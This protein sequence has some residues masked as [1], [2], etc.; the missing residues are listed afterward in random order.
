MKK[1]RKSKLYHK[2]AI[3]VA[4][5]LT[6]VALPGSTLNARVGV[7]NMTSPT[8]LSQMT[9]NDKDVTTGAGISTKIIDNSIS[10]YAM[11]LLELS[12]LPY[13]D[14]SKQSR[15]LDYKIMN[16]ELTW[17]NIITLV[18]IGIDKPPYT[19]AVVISEIHA[20]DVDVLVNKYHQLPNKFTPKSLKKLPNKYVRKGA[21]NAYL[22]Y[23]A[24]S[25][26]IKLCNDA[27]NAGYNL[28][29]ST[30]YRDFRLQESFYNSYVKH[31]GGGDKGRKE[32]D[33]YSARPGFS[34]HQ[35]GL[36]VDVIMG[37][38]NAHIEK[39]PVYKWYIERIHKYGFI[40]R[41][42][43]GKQKITG[44]EFWE[45]WH[46]RYLG[47]ELA[48]KVYNSGLSYDEYYVRYI[49]PNITKEPII[50]DESISK[51]KDNGIKK[52]LKH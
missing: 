42:P 15:Y 32:A 37:D 48:I 24:F 41:Y 40:L 34:E 21:R 39:Q 1:N 14:F 38:R 25:A 16:S 3:A 30:A 52:T 51:E 11:E 10:K 35:T 26:F 12:S 13:Y 36:A 22:R 31:E 29:A 5:T 4:T 44:Y 43:D 28:Y 47:V 46:L 27:T 9:N 7:I 2:G 6:I 19:N 49:A 20:H 45:P 17:E 33:K 8:L 18:N 50:D 23:D